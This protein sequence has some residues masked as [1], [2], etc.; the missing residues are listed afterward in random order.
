MLRESY[1]NCNCESI[2]HG[3]H[4]RISPLGVGVCTLLVGAC[5]KLVIELLYFMGGEDKASPFGSPWDPFPSAFGKKRT[6]RY[7]YGHP[8]ACCEQVHALGN[9]AGAFP[10]FRD[11]V[12][13]GGAL[14]PLLQQ[15]MEQ[16]KL[17]MLRIATWALKN[18]CREISPT[19]LEQVSL[20][21]PTLV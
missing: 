9:M 20:A 4:I 3:K 14:G 8:S 10:F 5:Q 13:Q 17:S 12:L 15:L 18:I 21:L 1:L 2:V 6:P 19:W 11:K 7:I 16:S